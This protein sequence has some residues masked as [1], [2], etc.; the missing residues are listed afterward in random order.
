MASVQILNLTHVVGSK[1][2]GVG[3]KLEEMNDKVDIVMKGTPVLL[4]V[5]PSIVIDSRICSPV[6][7]DAK[8]LLQQTSNDIDKMKCSRSILRL[9]RCS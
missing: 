8:E 4:T 7:K 6:G 3:N 9:L 5:Y 1:V 2:T